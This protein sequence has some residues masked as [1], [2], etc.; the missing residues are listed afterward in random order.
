MIRFSPALSLICFLVLLLGCEDQVVTPEATGRLDTQEGASKVAPVLNFTAPLSGDQEV[1]PV[2][3]TATGLA[4][5]RLSKDGTELSY[6][7][8]VANIDDV[9][10]AHIHQAGA[11]QNGPIVA[12]LYPGAPPPVLIPGTSN[13]V[14]AEGVVTEANLMGPLA[15]EPLSALIEA[16]AGGGTY[17]NVHTSANPGGAVRGQIVHGNGAH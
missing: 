12:W 1:P 13:G 11:G 15:G 2:A 14:L 8:I 17:V 16:M 4:K 6:K 5:F 10:M 9:L 3:T 7:L